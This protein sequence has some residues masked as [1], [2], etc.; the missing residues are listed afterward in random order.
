MGSAPAGTISASAA[1]LSGVAC[2]RLVSAVVALQSIRLGRIHD[3]CTS[4]FCSGSWEDFR[5]L[6][7]LTRKFVKGSGSEWNLG[8][9]N[10]AFPSFSLGRSLPRQRLVARFQNINPSRALRTTRG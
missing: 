8:T 10:P 3:E 4:R 9:P 2:R 5:Q 7:I 1:P 6:D